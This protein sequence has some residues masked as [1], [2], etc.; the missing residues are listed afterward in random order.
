MITKADVSEDE[1]KRFCNLKWTVIYTVRTWYAHVT[2]IFPLNNMI[3][4][5]T[6]TLYC[7]TINFSFK[8]FE[9]LKVLFIGS[10]V[11]IVWGGFQ[12][13]TKLTKMGFFLK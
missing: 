4:L 2:Y 10:K 7:V 1:R 12:Q 6:N 9:C 3:L 8:N 11:L 5:E 13:K